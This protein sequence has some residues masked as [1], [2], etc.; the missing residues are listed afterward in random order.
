MGAKK[1]KRS[2]K[3]RFAVGA[4][5]RVKLPGVNGIVTQADSALTV[6]GEYWHTVQTQ[7]GKRRE[8]GSNLQLV[9][10]P[11]ANAKPKGPSRPATGQQLL[12]PDQAIS[13]LKARLEIAVEDLR[14]DDPKVD[15]WERVTKKIVER[16]FGERSQNANYFAVTLSYARQSEEE[17]QAWHEQHFKEKKDLLR[18]FIEELEII[19][20]QHT[21]DS[22]LHFERM[23]VDEARKSNAEDDR[24][25]PFVG[26]VVVKNGQ[27]LATSHRGEV[28]GNHAE[29]I[30]LEIKLKDASI[31]GCTVYTTL[32]PCT[33]RNNPKI[34]CANRLIERRVARVVVG[35]HDPNPEICGKGIRKL[36]EANIEVVLF[37]HELIKELEE[38]NRHFTRSHSGAAMPSVIPRLKEL[39]SLLWKAR[40]GCQAWKNSPLAV[41][42]QVLVGSAGSKWNEPDPEDGVYSLDAQRGAVNWFAR[43]PADANRVMLSKGVVVTGC[44]D[45]SVVAISA[46][47]GSQIWQIQLDSGIVGG[48]VKLSANIW[49]AKARLPA[50]AKENADPLLVVT[51]GGHLYLLDLSTGRRLQEVDIGHKVVGEPLLFQLRN[52]NMLAVPTVDGVLVFLEYHDIFVALAKVTEVALRYPNGFDPCGYSTP[53]L[54][55]QPAWSDGFVLQGIVRDTYYPEAPIIAI[56]AQTKEV[57][58]I[59]ADPEGR[60]G[61][62]GNL[63]GAPLVLGRE[64]IFVPAYSKYMFA[65]SVDDGSLLWMVDLG[66]GMFEQWCGPIAGNESIYIGRH[67]GYLHRVD[68]RGHR[69]DWSM[70]LGSERNAGTVVSGRQRL[71]EFDAASSWRSG[72]SW[73]ILGTPTL[74]QGRLYVGTQEGYLYCLANLGEE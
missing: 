55:S 37:P 68:T 43:T 12:P 30:A 39:P 1:F 60:G 52:S 35:M 65:L 63:R 23:A 13:L 58:W 20:P 62:F 56:D 72:D 31:A 2:P 6:L 16:A 4:E 9:P 47:D 26:C 11:M 17:K 70:F 61:G 59:G 34:A 22:D 3:K 71:P 28:K 19:P 44:D 36:Q 10:T 7:F 38:L 18:A 33:K 48:P 49:G 5:V 45:G 51:F 67:D 29:Y 41:G 74:D 21:Q 14:H 73:P 66:Q 54:A 64:V 8:P 40:V 15:S 24:A 32:E 57:R 25:R 46:R 27:V 50:Y 42:N 69:R 53:V